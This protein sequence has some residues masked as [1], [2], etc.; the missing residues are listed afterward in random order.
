MLPDSP[1]PSFLKTIMWDEGKA[2]AY[3]KDLEELGLSISSMHVGFLFGKDVKVGCGELVEFS[4]RSGIRH[5]MTSLEFDTQQKAEEAAVL[6]NTAEEAL[7]GTGVSLGYHNH[8][9]EF[10]PYQDGTL[11]DYFLELTHPEVKLQVDIGW[12]MYG[13][14]EVVPFLRKNKDRIVSV[15]LKDFV[16]GFEK[17]EKDDA[18]A[19]FINDN[20][21]GISACG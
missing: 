8:Y 1:V 3:Q 6:L 9:M 4:Q 2:L 10:Q 18:F 7:R 14:S 11:M 17:V 21:H 20:E 13:G 15:H 19:A 12:Q 5:F 16:K